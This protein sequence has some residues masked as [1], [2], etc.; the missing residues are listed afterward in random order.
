MWWTNTVGYVLSTVVGHL[1]VK[2]SVDALWA[3]QGIVGE[4]RE[5]WHPAFLGILERSL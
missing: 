4:D 2:A 3:G 1:L 5:P